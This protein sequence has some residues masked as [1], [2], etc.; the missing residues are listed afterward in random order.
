M[1]V[2]G[3][4]GYS[5]AKGVTLNPNLDFWMKYGPTIVQGGMGL[6]GLKR[7]GMIP[8][9]AEG[10]LETLLGFGCGYVLGKIF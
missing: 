5:H 8:N 2:G 4:H 9:G 3:Y 1:I 10:A 7:G 6:V